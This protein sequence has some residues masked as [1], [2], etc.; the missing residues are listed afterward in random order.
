LALA[1]RHNQLQVRKATMATIL[2]LA[3]SLQRLA[4]VVAKML[5]TGLQAVRVVVVVR[6]RT[7][8]LVQ[9][10]KVLQAVRVV[11]EL[12]AGEAVARALLDLTRSADSHH[13]T[14]ATA[15][16]ALQQEYQVHQHIT[17]VARAVKRLRAVLLV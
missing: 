2:C 1:V 14:V 6:K 16:L 5:L 4:V 3:R 11:A 7:V 13:M 9:Q 15:A 10:I 12:A 17:Q 8:V